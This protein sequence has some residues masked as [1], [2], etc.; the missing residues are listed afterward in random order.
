[1]VEAVPE[2]R[3]AQEEGGADGAQV[4]QDVLV[5]GVLPATGQA[6]ACAGET[7]L[8]EKGKDG[9]GKGNE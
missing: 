1:M 7:G 3:E 2:V 5:G 9:E 8:K 4:S 6:E